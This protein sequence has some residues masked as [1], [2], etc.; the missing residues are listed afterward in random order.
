[1]CAEDGVVRSKT[2]T[3]ANKL[4]A[5]FSVQFGRSRE[6]SVQ[7]ASLKFELIP[8]GQLPVPPPAATAPTSMS[9]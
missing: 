9:H 7:N 4:A 8:N 5:E 1:M 3:P 6:F 2:A